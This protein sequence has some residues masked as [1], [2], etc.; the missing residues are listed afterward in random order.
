M[1]TFIRYI[2]NLI[3]NKVL[4]CLQTIHFFSETFSSNS[5]KLLHLMMSKSV[6]LNQKFS[7]K[8]RHAE[9]CYVTP[10]MSLFL[11]CI[12]SGLSQKMA[13]VAD[14]NLRVVEKAANQKPCL[15][16]ACQSIL[17]SCLYVCNMR[18]QQ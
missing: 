8:I 11:S 14:L 6:D 12:N 13:A 15:F 10:N 4:C 3:I 17:N 7:G 18:E 9:L 1:H 5:F 16:C 2:I